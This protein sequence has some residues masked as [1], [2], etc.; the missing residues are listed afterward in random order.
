MNLD[1][2]DWLPEGTMQIPLLGDV[3]AGRPLDVF[4]VEQTLD[5][6]ESLW[7]G[8]RLFALR[9]RGQSM[10]DA[11][12]R[13]GDYLII[14][15]HDTA[16]DGR[17]VVAEVDGRVT[18]KKIYRQQDGTVRLVPANPELL[19]FVVPGEEVRVRGVVVGILRKYG[20]GQPSRRSA[21]TERSA[22]SPTSATSMTPRRQVGD[23]ATLDLAL[24]ALDAQIAEW[25]NALPQVNSRTGR[26]ERIQGA[27]VIRD[28]QALRDWCGRTGRPAL[29]RALLAEANR[30]IQRGKR[31]GIFRLLDLPD[32]VLH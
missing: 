17:T 18:V 23:E 29:R 7:N 19:P 5:I 27:Q 9:V 2:G 24:N 26:N 30:L 21:P 25:R 13:D 10:I 16:D 1:Q 12:I 11:G 22:T 31:M 8:R 6:P 32:T 15:P 3:A 20:F 4:T 28:L 14:E